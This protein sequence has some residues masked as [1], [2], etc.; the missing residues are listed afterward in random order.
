MEIFNIL[1]QS[2][3][4]C[5]FSFCYYCTQSFVKCADSVRCRNFGEEEQLLKKFCEDILESGSLYRKSG[6]LFHLSA[7]SIKWVSNSTTEGTGCK[8][9]SVA[10]KSFSTRKTQI[11]RDLRCQEF[12]PVRGGEAQRSCVLNCTL[13]QWFPQIIFLPFSSFS[14]SRKKRNTFQGVSQPEA[15]F[16]LFP[17]SPPHLLKYRT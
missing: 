12:L 2:F 15:F 1:N 10:C 13:Q 11:L 9:W 6:A 5:S 7:C 4:V 8:T 16:L 3:P 14:P 17:L